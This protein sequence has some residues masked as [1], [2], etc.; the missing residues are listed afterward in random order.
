MANEKRLIDAN[1]FVEKLQTDFKRVF[2]NAGKKVKPED[3]YIERKAVYNEDFY[4]AEIDDFCLMVDCFPT[5]DAVEVVHSEWI[6]NSDGSGTCKHCHRTTKN[7]WDYD[8]CMNF[9][10]GCG[11]DMR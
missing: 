3:Y 11:A 9:C 4:K 5:V 7:A 10:P 8:R 1:A 2:T 6:F